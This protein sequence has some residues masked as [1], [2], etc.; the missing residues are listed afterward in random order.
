MRFSYFG[1][2]I[3]LPSFVTHI[4]SD[5]R[6]TFYRRIFNLAQLL[7][8]REFLLPDVYGAINLTLL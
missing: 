5:S 7:L 6:D 4:L 3:F 1:K 8:F 2:Q